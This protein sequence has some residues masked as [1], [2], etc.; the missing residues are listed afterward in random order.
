MLL[1]PRKDCSMWRWLI[2]VLEA[3]VRAAVRTAG[4]GIQVWALLIVEGIS[5]LLLQRPE[6][7]GVRVEASWILKQAMLLTL[8]AG[9][10]VML[11]ELT[12]SG[13]EEVARRIPPGAGKIT[14]L[15]MALVA[16]G[17]TW[18]L[19]NMPQTATHG[20]VR[21]DGPARET[22]N[23]ALSRHQMGM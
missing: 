17:M 8:L 19:W 21:A 6:F 7:D 14:K 15:S 20:P 16:A 13:V 18:F 23:W 2:E 9:W 11:S 5:H 10:T 22:A 1:F 3:D 4:H 12:V